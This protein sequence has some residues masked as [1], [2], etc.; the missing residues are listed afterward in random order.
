MEEWYPGFV[1]EL[2]LREAALDPKWG[3]SRGSPT[4]CWW[5]PSGGDCAQSIVPRRSAGRTAAHSL[6][7]IAACRFS[8][9]SQPPPP[10]PPP[11]ITSSDGSWR[12]I[13]IKASLHASLV[14]NANIA[15]ISQKVHQA[16]ASA[17]ATHACERLRTFYHFSQATLDDATAILASDLDALGYSRMQWTELTR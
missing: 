11:R 8:T 2:G 5:K 14:A 13:P 9:M 12:F 4:G 15:T 17:H 6:T 7:G 3:P 10:P 16:P 1:E